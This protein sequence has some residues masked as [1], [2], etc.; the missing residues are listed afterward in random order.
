MKKEAIAIF[1]IGKTNKKF[2]L[3]DKSLKLF[4][5]YEEKFSEIQDEDGF[6]CDDHNR[7]R[8]WIVDTL[9]QYLNHPEVE[10]KAVNFSTYG[11]TL[12]FLDAQGKE[13]TPLYNYL[14]PMAAEITEPLY[15]K[16]GGVDEFSR[17]TASPAL[18]F[19]NSGLQ[20]LWLKKTKPDA[21]DKVK[22]ILHFPQYCSYL[23]TGKISSE[24]TSIGCHTA[25]WD[26]DNMAYH[27]WLAEEGISLPEPIPNETIFSSS[28]PEFTFGIGTGIHD[29]SASLAPY[30]MQ[31]KEK[32]LI[33]S[34][35]TWCINM[36]PFNDEPLTPEQLRSDCLSYMSINRKPVKSSR[37]FM[38]HMHDVNLEKINEHFQPPKGAYKTVKLDEQI[39]N[40]L[41]NSN[42]RY[43]SNGIPDD[44]IDRDIDLSLFSSFEE[45]YHRLMIDL[46]DLCIKSIGLILPKKDDIGHIYISG[47]FAKNEIFVRYL[48]ES[49][50]D[51][52]IFTSEI[53]NA[54]ALGAAMVVHKGAGIGELPAID[55]GLEEWKKI[56][57]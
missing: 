43:F 44:Y 28:I 54:T 57:G 33:L 53:D 41:I 20:A 34:T 22:T 48:A 5:E 19:L 29:S 12:M 21:F 40:K 2:L 51:K 8:Q 11:A 30:L 49:M 16:H 39:F 50:P 10:I 45:A 37:L 46:T 4:H 25:M 27:P 26:F 31:S 9:K 52:R 7:I 36:N 23:L 18:G 1:D 47:G 15:E 24:Y 55:L 56:S 3:F 14:K 6:G 32:F 13:L 38:G 42:I 17:K 35:G